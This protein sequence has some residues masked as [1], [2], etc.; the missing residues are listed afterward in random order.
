M[1]HKVR[2][3]YEELGSLV[4]ARLN[5]LE[6]NN[7]EWFHKHTDLIEGMMKEYFPHGSGFDCGTTLDF[8]KSTAEKL[9]ISTE[10]HHMNEAGMYDGWTSHQIIV[11][12][13]FVGGYSMRITGRDRNGIKEYIADT[14]SACLDAEWTHP[15]YADMAARD[16][17]REIRDFSEFPSGDY[18]LIG[19]DTDMSAILH[20]IK[21]EGEEPR[22][23]LVR[24]DPNT[25]KPTEVWGWIGGEN[26]KP[27]TFITLIR[28]DFPQYPEPIRD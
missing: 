9:V 2:N 14:F 3:V 11:T 7:E 4:S 23:L 26:C 8:E 25:F 27:C 13:S 18:N 20:H 15:V 5:C 17:G 21:W 6:S 1:P 16:G 10:Y 24:E 28:M 19:I 12:P 22:F